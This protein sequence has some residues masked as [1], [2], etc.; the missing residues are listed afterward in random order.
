[1]E[2]KTNVIKIQRYHSPCGDLMLGSFED[3]LCLCDWAAESHRDIVD[4]RLR[5]VLKAGY[6]KSTSDVILEAMSQLDEYFNGERT[7]FEVPLLFVG[8]EFQKSVWYKLLEIPY[9]ST[10]SYGELAKQLDLPKAVRAVAAANGAN[11]ISI[12]APCHRVIGSNH[13]LVGYGGGGSA[14]AGG[15][16]VRG[17]NTVDL[18]TAEA[19]NIPFEVLQ[20]VMSRIINEVKGVNRCFYDITSKPPGTIEFE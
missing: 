12:F 7:V 16:A 13:S 15:C 11:A 17:V 20:R 1:M 10:V 9:G 2:D 3:K 19:A 18:M 5:K 8:T 14:G 4:R 6:E